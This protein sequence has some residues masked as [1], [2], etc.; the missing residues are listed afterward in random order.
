MLACPPGEWGLSSLQIHADPS[1]DRDSVSSFQLVLA[2]PAEIGEEGLPPR[3]ED[4]SETRFL[5]SSTLRASLFSGKAEFWR[6]RARI[7]GTIGEQLLRQSGGA[8]RPTL[9]DLHLRHGEQQ[10][11]TVPHALCLRPSSKDLHFIHLTDLHVAARNDLMEQEI[12]STVDAVPPGTKLEFINFNNRLRSFIQRANYLADSGE[13]DFVLALGDLVDFV[14]QGLGEDQA[15]N[16]NWQTLADIFTGGGCEKSA[17]NN[18]GLRVPMLTTTGNHDWRPFPYD[19][20]LNAKTFRTPKKDLDEFDYLYAD[21]TEAVGAKIAEVHSKLI[22]KG[23]PI[24]ARSWWGTAT[25]KG[26]SWFMSLGARLWTRTLAI[27]TRFLRTVL[28]LLFAAGSGIVYGSRSWLSQGLAKLASRMHLGTWSSYSWFA[29]GFVA[30][31]GLVAAA[32]ALA[33][34]LALLRMIGDWLTEA[35]RK[36]ITG[37]IAIESGANGLNDYFL[38]FNPYFNYAFGLEDCY[39]VIMDS[40]HD[41]LTGQSFWDEGGKKIRR[42]T[43]K[44]NILGGSP[45]SMAFFPPNEF[46]PYSQIAWLE[47]V[48]DCIRRRHAQPAPEV[49]R[50]YRTIVGLHAPPSNLSPKQRVRADRQR[51][52]QPLLLPR[53]F[54]HSYDIHYGTINHYV[55]QF[56]YICLGFR[57]S[58]LGAPRGPGID[59]VLSGHAHWNIEFRLQRPRNVSIQA[60]WH[61][62]V[63]YGEFSSEVEAH[64]NQPNLEWNPLLLQTAACGPPSD[65]AQKN[66]YYRRIHIDASRAIK[67]LRPV[68]VE[69]DVMP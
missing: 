57:E 10:L 2:E 65:T 48:L 47:T 39:F 26:L 5:I 17:R 49:L 67:R 35:L 28:T 55:S 64:P 36:K 4:V 13:L 25:G 32:A 11:H 43:I 46:Y 50:P 19:P 12:N 66:P 63:Y 41:A 1:Y 42:L 54:W 15:E 51:G 22:A 31:L 6:V 27:G 33:L 40:G 14:H 58:D 61:P 37:L 38:K 9:F 8:P 24:L 52:K 16:S 7:S 59:L 68:S 18:E 21:T 62:E 20:G 3:F 69:E 60:P 34:A 23:S 29:R 44:D 45:E 56:F 30:S 53:K